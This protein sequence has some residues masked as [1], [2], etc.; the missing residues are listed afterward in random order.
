MDRKVDMTWRSFVKGSVPAV[1]VAWIAL[2]LTAQSSNSGSAGICVVAVRDSGLFT[3]CPSASLVK[4]WGYLGRT[5]SLEI[6]QNPD[7]PRLAL[8]RHLIQLDRPVLDRSRAGLVADHRE[9]RRAYARQGVI[10]LDLKKEIEAEFSQRDDYRLVDSPEKAD[11]V[12]LAEGIYADLYSGF[13]G[14]PS[15][16]S[17]SSGNPVPAAHNG[18][19]RSGR[20]LHPGTCRH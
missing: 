6:I 19:C 2:S 3:M 15:G 10:D 1:L 13:I 8:P 11:L 4:K 20:C 5:Q 18:D 14:V 9:W 7:G 12:F 16:R 17:R